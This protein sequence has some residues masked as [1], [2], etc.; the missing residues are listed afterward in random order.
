MT[1]DS[2]LKAAGSFIK[3]AKLNEWDQES[4]IAFVAYLA[5]QE[6]PKAEELPKWLLAVGAACPAVLAN[7]SA[8]RQLLQS[9][10]V[11][12]LPKGEATQLGNRFAGL[13]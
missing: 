1:K 3:A 4:H 8:F 9:D 6:K 13:I 11:A 12:L 2:I 10:K 5:K 7:A